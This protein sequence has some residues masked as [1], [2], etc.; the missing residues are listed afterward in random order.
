ML[1]YD[2]FNE[3]SCEIQ[4]APCGLPP[5][6]AAGAKWL[7]PF[8]AELLPAMRA[9]DPRHPVF[10]ED[11]LTTA[12]GYP[13]TLDGALRRGQGLVLPRLLPAPAALGALLRGPRARGAS[14]ARWRSPAAAAS[15]RC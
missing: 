6:P 10:Y 1:G 9:A 14:S 12:F 11:F 3:P 2:A 8:Y 13:Y 15:P 4:R 7:A 5:D